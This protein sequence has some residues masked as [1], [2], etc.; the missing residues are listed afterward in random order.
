MD[1]DRVQE[2]EK[3]INESQNGK[4]S[5]PPLKKGSFAERKASGIRRSTIDYSEQQYLDIQEIA[6][7]LKIPI[8]A[9]VKMAVHDFIL[10]HKIAFNKAK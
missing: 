4:N 8:Q 6:T 9:A 3:K 7:Y 5:V 2:I 1:Y 10:R